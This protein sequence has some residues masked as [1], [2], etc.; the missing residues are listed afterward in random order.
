[1][2]GIEK[3]VQD[4]TSYILTYKPDRPIMA[5][6]G[7]PS[8]IE[9]CL[10]QIKGV[11]FVWHDSNSAFGMKDFDGNLIVPLVEGEKNAK[12]FRKTHP[13][14]PFLC[15]IYVEHP[16][17][18][19]IPNLDRSFIPVY[20]ICP[21]AFYRCMNDYANNTKYGVDAVIP[22]QEPQ[23]SDLVL[24]YVRHYGNVFKKYSK[25]F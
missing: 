13:S 5:L 11:R 6:I 10:Q 9:W 22:D 15:L 21:K 2:D 18:D 3:M 12:K 17:N 19:A 1:M 16:Y 7:M 14:V 4:I 25:L 23:Q 8:N 24:A 20:T